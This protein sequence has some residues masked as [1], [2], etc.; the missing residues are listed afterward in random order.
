MKR[1]MAIVPVLSGLG[2]FGGVALAAVQSPT[3][4]ASDGFM[5]GI[6]AGFMLGQGVVF[7]GVTHL[8][9]TFGAYGQTNK[10]ITQTQKFITETQLM[11]HQQYLAERDQA[12][13][14]RL[15]LTTKEV[16]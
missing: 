11:M 5:V 15:A 3:V 12:R 6:A 16:A 10:E 4:Q 8:F 13:K 1:G 9:K 2:V 14:D 7:F